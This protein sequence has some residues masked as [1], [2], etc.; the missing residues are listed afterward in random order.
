MPD[1]TDIPYLPVEEQVEA[2]KKASQIALRPL[3][4]NGELSEEE[5]YEVI[6]VF[7]VYKVG[8]DYKVGD[9]FSYNE[10]LYEVL[11]SHKSQEDWPPDTTAR[12]ITNQP[13][14]ERIKGV[15]NNG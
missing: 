4:V 15:N 3:I 14:Y 2:L 7:P 13:P 8:V 6:D 5:M 12:R 11:Q 1:F 10:C 9:I